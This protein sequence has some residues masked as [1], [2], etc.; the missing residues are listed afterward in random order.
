MIE[1][2]QQLLQQWAALAPDEC[3]TAGHYRFQI[4]TLP[5]VE[6]SSFSNP[7]R[8]INSEN[9]TWRLHLGEDLI[10]EQL[11]F[12]LL[13]VLY[14]CS[15]RQSDINFTMIEQGTI[16]TISNGL[17]SQPHPHPALAALDAYVQLLE[18]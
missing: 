14:R 9:F 16:V 5:M 8:S 15:A 18:F 12:V 2:Y 11:N 4:K 1:T 10:L 7:W 17:K 13:T 3:S 6:K